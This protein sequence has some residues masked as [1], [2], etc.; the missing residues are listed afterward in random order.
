MFMLAG[1]LWVR[2]HG[3]SDERCRGGKRF[4]SASRHGPPASRKNKP[5][6]FREALRIVR[7]GHRWLQLGV[8][9]PTQAPRWRRKKELKRRGRAREFEGSRALPLDVARVALT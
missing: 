8:L 3:L 9:C 5:F 2:G 1:V 7:S 4:A 6:S